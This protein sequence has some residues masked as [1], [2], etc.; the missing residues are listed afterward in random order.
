MIANV[1]DLGVLHMFQREMKP[2]RTV[3]EHLGGLHPC[4]CV[5]QWISACS[6]T[7]AKTIPIFRIIIHTKLNQSKLYGRKRRQL[8]MGSSKLQIK[9]YLFFLAYLPPS[10]F[11]YPDI[12]GKVWVLFCSLALFF[13]F[14]LICSSPLRFY[15]PTPRISIIAQCNK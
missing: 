7:S 4:L 13:P 12:L 1:I 2:G 5:L 10:E 14:F 8:I 11:L 9:K 3:L 15:Q 6:E